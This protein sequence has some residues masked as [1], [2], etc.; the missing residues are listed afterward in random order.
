[1]TFRIERLA[2]R[3]NATVLR[4]CGRVQIE[5]VSTIK[6]LIE[7]ENAKIVLDLLEVT[8]GG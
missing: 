5:C 8:L 1:M 4:V 2:G 6:G 3:E 7:A